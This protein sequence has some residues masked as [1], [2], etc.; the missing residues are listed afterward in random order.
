MQRDIHQSIALIQETFG[1]ELDIVAR[2]D[3][4]V[5]TVVI[6]R[7]ILA[8]TASIEIQNE[9]H[10]S[11]TIS[12]EGTQHQNKDNLVIFEGKDREE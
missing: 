1:N 11:I 6:P 8:G 9:T 7:D 3:V 12:V 10:E 2:C 5:S 4:I